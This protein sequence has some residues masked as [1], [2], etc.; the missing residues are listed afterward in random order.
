MKS[1]FTLLTLLPL[2]C[3]VHAQHIRLLQPQFHTVRLRV[4]G[5]FRLPPVIRLGSD[6]RL[7]L[8]FDGLTHDI[9]RYRYILTHCDAEGTPSD[10][11]ETEYLQGFNDNL[12]ETADP[13]V[14]TT[15][16]Y[17]HY[18]LMLPNRDVSPTLSG[19][20]RI[21]VY[22]EDEGRDHPAF[23]ACFKIVEPAVQIAA[24]VSSDT[25]IDRNKTHQQVSFT[26]FHKGY[27][28]RH[29][30]QELKVYVYQNNRTDNR[31][32]GL[33]PSFVGADQLRYEHNRALIFEAGNEY[34]RF[35]TVNLH[36]P[37]RGVDHISYHAPYYHATLPI[38]LP[39][40]LN[41]SYD[42]DQNGRF[43]IRYDR[44][45]ESSD[46][47]ADYLLTHF[48]FRP[49]AP[50]GAGSFYLD[51]DLTNHTFTEANR[52]VY[53]A[54]E[55]WYECTLL[56]KQG[57]YNYQ[58]LYLAPEATAGTTSRSEGNFHETENEYLI[59]VYHRPFG[60]RYDR[61]IGVQR[62]GN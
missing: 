8:S 4:N 52:L 61:L 22:D 19:N 30:G 37:M 41:Y 45:V 11:S 29:P 48:A 3:G 25:D 7:E 24:R 47:E 10:L 62:I 16:P 39:R 5:D 43:L 17:T 9:H 28:I 35:E 51:G 42:Q 33:T 60:E 46:I 14:N 38:D 1:I 49:S 36:A 27:S 6:D 57:A 26:L 23:T 34:R 40:L 53:N 2:W 58:Y 21:T 13:S 50:L 56:L 32:G 18:S 31:A 59:L 12:I 20:Y 54:D 44:A 55:D 15:L